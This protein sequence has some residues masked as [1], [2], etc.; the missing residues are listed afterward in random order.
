M[1]KKPRPTSEEAPKPSMDDSRL[2]EL[3]EG[4]STHVWTYGASEALRGYLILS[5]LCDPVSYVF[6]RRN[7]V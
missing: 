3:L 7:S 2:R 6:E 5:W 4:A 1:T